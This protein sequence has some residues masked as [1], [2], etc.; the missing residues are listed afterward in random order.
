VATQ[1]VTGRVL[2]SLG[3][4]G[5]AESQFEPCADV[6]K[7]G[8]LLGLPDKFIMVHDREAYSPEGLKRLK[9]RRI[10]CLTYHKRK[11]ERGAV[12]RLCEE[13]TATH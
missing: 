9:E 13:L 11:A 10:G 12:E 5:P 6:P 7:G 1:N 4:G 8:V 2:A 3:K